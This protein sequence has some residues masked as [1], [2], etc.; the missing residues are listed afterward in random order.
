MYNDLDYSRQCRR[1]GF[2]VRQS[3]YTC[4]NRWIGLAIVGVSCL[5]QKCGPRQA[6]SGIQS[7]QRLLQRRCFD[8]RQTGR[9]T[10][11]AGNTVTDQ[12]AQG[13]AG[14]CLDKQFRAELLP[15][16]LHVAQP[17]NRRIQMFSQQAP[18]FIRCG[19]DY[20]TLMVR[21]HRDQRR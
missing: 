14:P 4:R 21:Q 10:F 11:R 2:D 9:Q 12:I 17:I 5:L 3:V 15:Q 13:L 7:G 1:I 8:R 16:T 18:D 20:T 19:W 6:T